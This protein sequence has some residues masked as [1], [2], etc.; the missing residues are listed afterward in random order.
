MKELEQFLNYMATNPNVI[1]KYYKY[2]MI[3]NI[4]SD[5]SCLTEKKGRS[6]IGYHYLLDSIQRKTNTIKINCTIHNV[7]IIIRHVSRS[8]AEAELGE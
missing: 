5:A 2:D 3:L 7:F 6:I 1:V 4:H 8:A